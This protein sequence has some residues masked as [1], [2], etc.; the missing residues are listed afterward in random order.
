MNRRLTLT[1]ALSV[2]VLAL[3]ASFSAR[4]T[5]THVAARSGYIVASS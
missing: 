5:T 4:P 3:A 1:L 2:V